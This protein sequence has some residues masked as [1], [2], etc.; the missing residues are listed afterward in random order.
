MFTPDPDPWL[1]ECFEPLADYLHLRLL[2]AEANP[3]QAALMSQGMSASILAAFR[4]GPAGFVTMARVAGVGPR[5]QEPPPANGTW[6]TDY[7]A[8]HLAAAGVTADTAGD[9]ARRMSADIAAAF[10]TLE[11]LDR[12][13]VDLDS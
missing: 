1:P 3:G 9:L 11:R 6:L 4:D 12:A 5:Q 10:A 8:R 7:L 2:S 13:G